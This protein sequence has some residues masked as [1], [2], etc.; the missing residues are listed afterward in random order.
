MTLIFAFILQAPVGAIAKSK[1][2][3]TDKVTYTV[4][5]A[6]PAG[7]GAD[8]VDVY[9]NNKLVIDNATPGAMASFTVDRGNQQ[10]KIYADG[11]LPTSDTPAVLTSKTVYL[12]NGAD[13][14]FVAHLA[15]DGKP[16]L[17]VFRNMI[18]SPGKKKAWL[19]A[20]HVAAA[21]NV[22][23]RADGKIALQ[24]LSNDWE[25]KATFAAKTYSVDAVL[26]DSHTVV[27]IAPIAVT[28]NSE[29]ST[30]VYAWGSAAQKNL[31]FSIQYVPVR[32]E[33]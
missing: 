1:A 14:T 23:I 9:A 25:R 30:V 20:R 15:L 10:I 8:K 6:I 2:K 21:P 3:S 17:D 5:H 22:D 28:L 31:R 18:T 16:H 7:N 32:K 33:S 12:S 27:A 24:N 4:L 19:V 13:V 26:A 11:V 29:S